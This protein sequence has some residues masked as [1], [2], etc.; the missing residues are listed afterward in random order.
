MIARTIAKS[1]PRRRL[2]YVEAHAASV[3]RVERLLAGRN[4]LLLMHARSLD[5]ALKQ[6]RAEPPEL[7]LIDVDL[8]AIGARELMKLLRA[9]PA[10]QD[11]PILALGANMAPDTVVKGLE[12]GFFHYLTKPVDGEALMEALAYALEFSAQERAEK[13]L[14][15]SR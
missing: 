3:A 13:T 4:D 15:E 14:K 9:N 11:A 10:T 2:L 12:A 5:V 6:A 8:V 1:A 7:M